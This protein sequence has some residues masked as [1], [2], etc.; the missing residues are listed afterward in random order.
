MVQVVAAAAR[1]T[2]RRSPGPYDSGRVL[3]DGP[4]TEAPGGR[5]GADTGETPRTTWRNATR[6]ERVA[7]PTPGREETKSGSGTTAV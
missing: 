3:T 7:A 6:A 5:Q 4:E 1:A 2:C